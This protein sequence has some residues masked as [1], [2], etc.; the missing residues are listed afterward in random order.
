MTSMKPI[1]THIEQGLFCFVAPSGENELRHDTPKNTHT[2][3][4][5]EVAFC[6]LII[7]LI[8]AVRQRHRKRKYLFC[9][10]LL[11]GNANEPRPELSR[12]IHEIP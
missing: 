11:D 2:H 9:W 12:K 10:L 8:L 4:Q 5:V 7:Y 6:L 3:T 1:K